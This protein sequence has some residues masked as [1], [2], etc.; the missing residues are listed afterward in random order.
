MPP[1]AAGLRLPRPQPRYLAAM[2]A[3]PLALAACDAEQSLAPDAPESAPPSVAADVTP[4]FA[5]TPQRIV[6]AIYRNGQYDISRMSATGQNPVALTSNSVHEMSPAWSFDNKR[7]A[8][9]RYRA[10][11]SYSRP[12]IYII[13]ADGTNGHWAR[14]QTC[15]CDLLYP[16]WSPDG[17]RLVVTMLYKGTYYV[18]YLI[19]GTGQLSAFSTGYGGLP[20]TAASYTKSGQII[21]V[22]PTYKTVFRMS[23][24]GTNIKAIFTA[25]TAIAQPALSPDGTKLAF[26][27]LIDADNNWDIFLRNL[28]TGTTTTIADSPAPDMNPSWSPDGSRIAFSSGRSGNVAQIYTMTPTGGSVTRISYSGKPEAMPAWSH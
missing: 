26:A 5:T 21:Y 6:Y 8:F 16:S 23:G 19:L 24:T 12:D 1:H 11:A 15:D 4:G 17:S 18:A 7:V 2:I 25:P 22:G 9:A 14:T 3:L 10:G 20:G 28:T 13:N 27:R